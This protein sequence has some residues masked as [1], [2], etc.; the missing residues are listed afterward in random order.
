MIGQEN[1]EKE[2]RDTARWGWGRCQR[3]GRSSSGELKEGNDRRGNWNGASPASLLEESFL[4]LSVV[5]QHSQ[6]DSRR[7][8]RG[9]AGTPATDHF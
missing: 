1:G 7:G 6:Q 5:T 8:D 2:N 4:R 3:S 9:Q